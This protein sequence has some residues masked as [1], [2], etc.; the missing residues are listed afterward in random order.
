MS[1]TVGLWLV[2]ASVVGGSSTADADP[3]KNEARQY[4]VYRYWDDDDWEDRREEYREWQED[5][6]EEMRVRYEEWRERQ[7][8]RHEDHGYYRFPRRDYPG[9]APRYP[10]YYEHYHRGP[11]YYRGP[12]YIQPLPR[13]GYGPRDW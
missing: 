1:H 8:N 6:R 3:W 9:Y 12:I 2:L 11:Y 5:R 4:R 10:R 7:E 13:H